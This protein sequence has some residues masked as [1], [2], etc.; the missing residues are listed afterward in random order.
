MRG[1]NLQAVQTVV[2]IARERDRYHGYASLELRE[3]LKAPPTRA[4][5][6]LALPAPGTKGDI[7][8]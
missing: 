3:L 8:H 4:E 5:N 1:G 2:K 6:P 7:G